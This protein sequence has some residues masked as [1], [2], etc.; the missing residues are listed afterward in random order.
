MLRFLVSQL[1][2][3]PARAT[4]L[5]GAVVVAAVAFVLLSSA[6]KTTDLRVKGSVRSN[7]R[8]A[9]DI[10][11][12]P[13]G[14]TTGLERRAG[15]V[16]PNYLSGIF[17]GITMKQY[18]RIKKIHGVEVAAPIANVGFVLPFA[19]TGI[20]LTKLLNLDPFQL[21]RIRAT[22]VAD[23]GT[24][25]YPGGSPYVYFTRRDRWIRSVGF[26]PGGELIRGSNELV[27]PCLGFA[28]SR[29]SAYGP[30]GGD[31]LSYMSCYSARSPQT[32]VDQWPQSNGVLPEGA[33]GTAVSGYFPIFVAAIDPVQEARLVHLDRTIVRGRYLR[34]SDAPKV[35]FTKPKLRP[36][37]PASFGRPTGKRYLPTIV[38][39]RAYVG[40]TLRLTIERLRLPKGVDVPRTLAQGRSYDFVMRLPG[41]QVERRCIPLSALYAFLFECRRSS[42]YAQALPDQNESDSY[43]TSSPTRYCVRDLDRVG[44]FVT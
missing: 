28:E 43:W 24:S 42:K 38:S 10:L 33:I 26:R 15:L 18:R 16:R 39:A 7:F 31:Q 29:P 22:W 41:H 25:R 30:F 27:D 19:S 9:Y 14:S 8:T 1:R 20:N 35:V 5:A 4:A 44:Q 37:E 3:S 2:H 34:E 36:G 17:G 23:D 13:P 6:A 40:E 21:Y 11:V 32:G 12:R